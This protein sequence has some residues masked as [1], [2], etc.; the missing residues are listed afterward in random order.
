MT[1]DGRVWERCRYIRTKGYVRINGE[2]LAIGKFVLGR[3]VR[4][5][6][7]GMPYIHFG[8]DGVGSVPLREHLARRA[9]EL[10]TG[11]VKLRWPGSAGMT[12]AKI[13]G[14]YR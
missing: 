12:D 7:D 14:R 3:V 9:H 4:V 13:R 11:R 8:G 1:A 6:N 5:G 10:A 2:T